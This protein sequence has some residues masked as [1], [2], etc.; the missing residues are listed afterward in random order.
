M[1]GPNVKIMT[2]MNSLV[3]RKIRVVLA[4]GRNYTGK[5]EGFDIQS[6]N[7]LLVNAEDSQGNVFPSVIIN[8]NMISEI[9][10]TEKKLFD[11]KEFRDLVIKKLGLR[12]YD[13]TVIEEAGTVVIMRKITVSEK[14][15]EGSGPLLNSVYAI[16]NE[17]MKKKQES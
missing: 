5:L 16:Y 6:F 12:E 8:G 1:R 15:V 11:P 9:I 2:K 3:G 13:V 17:Y 14:G 7:L 10:E 4:N